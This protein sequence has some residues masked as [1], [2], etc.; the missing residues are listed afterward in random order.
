M[1]GPLKVASDN[2]PVAL[3]GRKQRAVLAHLLL[4]A[5]ALVPADRLIDEDIWQ[6]QHMNIWLT[7]TG[8]FLPLALLTRTQLRR[9][10]IAFHTIP[11]FMFVAGL[12]GDLHVVQPGLDKF[13]QIFLVR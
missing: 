11:G 12:D 5:N 9:A 2:G 3:G 10:D 13:L 4:R 6:Q 7:T 1:L 8:T